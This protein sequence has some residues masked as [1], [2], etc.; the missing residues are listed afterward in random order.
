MV[1]GNLKP[2]M[3]TLA[4]DT[5]A[6]TTSVALLNDDNILAEIFMNS[7]R[8][9]AETLLPAIESLIGSV[10]LKAE[11][12]D[13]FAFTA[14]P[15]SF[16]GLR[17]GA[18]TIKG[19]AFVLDIPVVGVCTLDA[20]VL[21]IPDFLLK[22]AV[23]CPVLDAGRGEVYTTLYT[24]SEMGIYAKT[25]KE[26]VVRL[27]EFI[28]SMDG[29]VI[30]LG[31]AAEK[32]RNVIEELLP[33]RALFMPSNLNHVRAS[34]VGRVARGKFCAG[35]ISDIMTLTPDYLRASYATKG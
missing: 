10:G 23:V 34:A 11:Q 1:T 2:D 31:D 5:S 25:L 28:S 13:L 17:V 9:H 3:I 6:G 4:I 30:F 20:L 33:D 19:L 35:E 22:K 18:S 12:M 14:G 21:N 8:N 24:C 15:G 29:R 7:G 32:Y 26:C 16:T 27:D